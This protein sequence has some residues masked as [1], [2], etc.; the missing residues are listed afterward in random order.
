MNCSASAGLKLIIRH[1]TPT[2]ATI[3]D[4]TIGT[5]AGAKGAAPADWFLALADGSSTWMAHELRVALRLNETVGRPL[6]FLSGLHDTKRPRRFFRAT[7][8]SGRGSG[9]TDAP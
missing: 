4:G 8:R 2:W 6:L 7:R 3:P 1:S 5:A 9:D